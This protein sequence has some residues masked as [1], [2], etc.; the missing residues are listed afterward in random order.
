MDNQGGIYVSGSV[1]GRREY[2]AKK[3]GNVFYRHDVYFDGGI[4]RVFDTIQR[5]SFDLVPVRV[6]KD[7]QGPVFWVIDNG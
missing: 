2:V 5:E 1:V 3:T 7:Y 6:G 4:L